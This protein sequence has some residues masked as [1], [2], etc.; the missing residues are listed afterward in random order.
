MQVVTAPLSTTKAP[1]PNARVVRALLAAATLAACRT[2]APVPAPA[3]TATAA[4]IPDVPPP[5]AAPPTNWKS[6]GTLTQDEGDAR[7]RKELPACAHAFGMYWLPP[8]PC[9]NKGTRCMEMLDLSQGRWSCGCDLCSGSSDCKPAE[10]CGS[11]VPPCSNER[12]PLRCI[13]GPP[14]R[15]P[16]TS[17]PLPPP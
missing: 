1:R 9:A 13:D 6:D 12:R 3:A 15:C 8:S 16:T 17:P 4:P 11:D 5:P 14:A 7:C 2:V 10:H